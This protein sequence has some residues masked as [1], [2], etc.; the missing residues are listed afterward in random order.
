MP[1]KSAKRFWDNDMHGNARM[2]GSAKFCEHS[3]APHL[4]AGILSP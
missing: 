4:P 3:A 1:P 2:R